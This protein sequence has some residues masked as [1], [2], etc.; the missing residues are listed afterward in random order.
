MTDFPAEELKKDDMEQYQKDDTESCHLHHQAI[1]S[2]LSSN[3]FPGHFTLRPPLCGELS[4]RFAFGEFVMQFEAE[5][6]A[7]RPQ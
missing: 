1:L 4:L 3:D 6:A 7:M 2:C 5:D